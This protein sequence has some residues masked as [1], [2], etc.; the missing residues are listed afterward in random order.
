[1]KIVKDS[2]VKLERTI[3]D[4]HDEQFDSVKAILHDVKN[5]KDEA[6]RRLTEQFDHV[7]LNDIKVS[8]AEIIEAYGAVEKRFIEAV[9]QAISNIQ[10]F[11]EKQTRQSWMDTSPSG[12]ILGQLIR[13]LAK[14]GIY[15]PGGRAAYPSSVLMNAI[16]AQVAGVEEIVMVTPPNKNGKVNPGVLIAANELG[17][18]QIFKIG[19]AQAVGALAYGTQ[20]IPKVDKIT[21]PGNIFVALAKKEVY[22]LVD[23]DLVAGPSEILILADETAN[24]K[25]VAAD[26]LSQ[27]E[28][29]PLSSATL[30]T[31][32]ERLAYQVDTEIS[33]QLQHLPKREIAAE[34][35]EKQGAI[36]V[37]S[38]IAAAVQMANDFAPEH[39]E[40]L[41]KEPFSY[42]GQIKNAGAIFVGENSTEAIGDYFAGPNH[43]L[44]T[45][46]TAKFSSPLG[47]DDFLKKSSLISYSK[48]DL[49]EYADSIATLAQFEEL[50]GHANA[51]IFRKQNS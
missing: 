24:P 8:K 18:K 32:S 1:M 15:V 19:G 49:D 42:V 14:V 37:V 33:Q 39:L 16:P 50:Q 12:T 26:L 43:V 9:K 22:G 7:K 35:I 38:S 40:L 21:G 17:I 27:A 25:L 41:V 28:H 4:D 46:G 10:S 6:L 44:P 34:S 45:G 2:L 13:P 36:Y 29:D 5:N 20:S 31:V 30:I 3:L 11:H 51:V 23:I 47:V 48:N